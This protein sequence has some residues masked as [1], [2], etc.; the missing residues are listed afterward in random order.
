VL[1]RNTRSTVQ[2]S[3]NRRAVLG[4]RGIQRISLDLVACRCWLQ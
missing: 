4:A 1:F 3:L 2:K